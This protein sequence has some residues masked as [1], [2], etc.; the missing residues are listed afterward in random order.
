MDLYLK[1]AIEGGTVIVDGDLVS[2]ENIGSRYRVLKIP[3][4]RTAD[5]IGRRMTANMIML[6]A[7]VR[8]SGVIPIDSLVK[9]VADMVPPDTFGVNERAVRIGAG[10]I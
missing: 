10:L 3:A 9:A 2:T 7:L 8:E 4:I 6:G 5:E 1:D